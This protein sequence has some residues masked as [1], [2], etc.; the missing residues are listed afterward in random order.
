M[1]TSPLP[2]HILLWA[3][4]FKSPWDG[5]LLH[6]NAAAGTEKTI[7]YLA[8]GFRR[9]NH[10]VFVASQP[11]KTRLVNDVQYWCEADLHR[12]APAMEW[13]LIIGASY[14]HFQK[15]FEAYT[16]K[17]SVLWMHNTTYF[18]WWKGESLPLDEQSRLSQNIDHV[19]CLTEAHRRC[20]RS[21]YPAFRDKCTVIG[22]GI[23]LAPYKT[24]EPAMHKKGDADA[25]FTNMVFV[26]TSHPDRGLGTLLSMWERIS[27]SFV[28]AELL[29]FHPKYGSASM[30]KYA[31][32]V[33]TLTNVTVMGACD[34]ATL[35]A[36]LKR[37][38]YWIYPCTYN[39]TFCCSALEA[40]ACEAIPITTT[41]GALEEVVREKGIALRTTDSAD[42]LVNDVRTLERQPH[43]KALMRKN[44][45]AY[46][47]TIA[48]EDK[49]GQW[50]ALLGLPTMI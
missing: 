4:Y 31:Q 17:K 44:N 49:V 35:H 11:G 1:T 29:I 50:L 46:L 25:L 23:D 5:T 48:W 19:V 24:I 37:A 39:E 26:Y 27:R 33:G 42:D 20:V 28:G 2:K 45:L 6:T 10:R 43:V 41:V 3:G 47:G 30:D 12:H 34:T 7:I 38:D 22:H 9:R 36:H 21:T 13:D 16:Y 14:L 40:M 8:E 15:M 18:S 32:R